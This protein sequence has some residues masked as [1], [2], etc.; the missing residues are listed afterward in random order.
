MLMI[1]TDQDAVLAMKKKCVST[2]RSN[3]VFC[4]DIIFITKLNEI[5]IT[6]HI[7]LFKRR[8]KWKHIITDI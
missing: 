5:L 2:K 3:S 4:Y 1:F 7:F 8:K 6:F